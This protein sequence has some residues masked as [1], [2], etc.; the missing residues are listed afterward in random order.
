MYVNQSSQWVPQQGDLPGSVVFPVD[1]GVTAGPDTAL[2]LSRAL[3]LARWRSPAGLGF[4]ATVP[5]ILMARNIWNLITGTAPSNNPV[6]DLVKVYVGLLVVSVVIGL[7]V[8]G[9]QLLRRNPYITTY[10]YPGA[11]MSARLWPDALEL[12]LASGTRRIAFH[13]I[14]E[15]RP[16]AGAIFLRSNGAPVLVLPHELI[17]P[18]A[19]E[20]M[21]RSP[22][23]SAGSKSSFTFAGRP[24][25]LA[26]LAVVVSLAIV[27]AL[28]LIFRP[29]RSTSPAT[30]QATT[31]QESAGRS[32][33]AAPAVALP[34]PCALTVEQQQG[35][36]FIEDWKSTDWPNHHAC[37]W[38][39][40]DGGQQ[41]PYTWARVTVSVSPF[42]KDDQTKYETTPY[43]VKPAGNI[44]PAEGYFQ[45]PK[46][47][48]YDYIGTCI[49][50]WPT[51][52]GTAHLVLGIQDI[53]RTADVDALKRA[54]EQ[55]TDAVFATLPR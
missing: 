37:Q 43:A 39:M 17:P 53:T 12:S 5:L 28:A 26:G 48:G 22:D 18:A 13:E 44:V 23:S 46:G 25:P 15:V 29:H 14:R 19:L 52:Y 32:T 38:K 54:T 3:A 42:T 1:V 34:D 20:L 24:L 55:F 8:T 33:T 31:T 30:T 11:Q 21:G 16:L 47:S 45:R 51:S 49:I 50:V 2:R 9:V 27:V 10:A 4:I 6:F 35:F 41:R 36:G 7:L 40:Q